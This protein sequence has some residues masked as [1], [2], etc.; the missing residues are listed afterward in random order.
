MKS[1]DSEMAWAK[2]GDY[3]FGASVWNQ[4]GFYASIEGAN[5]VNQREHKGEMFYLEKRKSVFTIMVKRFD[6]YPTKKDPNGKKERFY[7]VGTMK[8]EQSDSYK[9]IGYTNTLVVKGV[10]VLKEFRREGVD[11]LLYS[12]IVEAGFT[13]F[14]DSEQYE[15]ARNLW[16]SLSNHPGFIVDIVDL[17]SRKIEY[18]NVELTKDDKRIWGDEK[19]T[20]PIELKIGRLR[21]LILTGVKF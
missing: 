16:I 5:I 20:D 6:D 21:R 11:K 14:G 19:S 9:R 4:N 1:E 10:Q 13:L 17:G 15:N 7:I 2:P 12:M 3:D 18:K 8:T